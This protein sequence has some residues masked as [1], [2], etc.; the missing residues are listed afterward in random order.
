MTI[1][2]TA[3]RRL[4]VA[5]FAVS[6]LAAHTVAAE[7]LRP[8]VLQA[9]RAKSF[10]VVSASPI[11][12]K[13]GAEVLRQGGNALD[14]AVAVQMVLGLVEPQSSGLG[15]ST[16]LLYYDK[17]AGELTAFDGHGTAPAA[18]TPDLFLDAAGQP[19]KASDAV[20][21][22]RA[23]G[24]PGTVRLWHSAHTKLGKLPWAKLL[25][26][27]I[28]LAGQG[29]EISPRL[30]A[31]IAYNRETLGRDQTAKSYFFAADGS[32]LPAGSRLKNPAL[33]ESLR[34]IA[35]GGA[36]A[37]Y[38]GPIAKDIVTKVTGFTANPGRLSEGDFKAYTVK[39]REAQCAPYRIYMVCGFPPPGSGGTA[40]GELLGMLAHFDMARTKP[41]GLDAVHLFLEAGKLTYADRDAYLA[42]PDFAPVPSSGLTDPLYLMMRAQL[43]DRDHAVPVPVRPGNPSWR[44]ADAGVPGETYEQTSTSHFAIVDKAGN[45]V[46][47]TSS[48]EDTFG[49]RLMVDGFLLNS[50]LADF[51]FRPEVNG[52]PVANRIEP[53]KRPRSAL[54]PTLVLD[55]TG[56]PM[57]ALG[58]AGGSRIIEYVAQTLV[59]VLDWGLDIQTAINLPRVANRNGLSELEAGTA[60]AGLKPGLEALGHSIALIELN[61]GVEGI[62]LGEGTLIGGIDPRREGAGVGE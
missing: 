51:S 56:K 47:A 52:R 59:G 44:D 7:D 24:V 40:L 30:A 22:G 28:D 12:S 17:A 35:A 13:A 49:S 25:Q 46:T 62:Q 8:Q 4:A 38:N 16:F 60:L 10:M 43:I 42:D 3:V 27:A 5:A 15:G 18:A 21:G 39:S 1:L 32:P 61:S 48:I 2:F 23:V 19:L 11:A 45:I 41:M 53:G 58:A 55:E 6:S 14:A 26:P 20:I 36:D 50:E 31:L 29:F 37:F 54:S 57:L 9:I 34:K 33:A